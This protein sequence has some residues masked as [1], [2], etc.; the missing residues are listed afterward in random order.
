[1]I[2][3]TVEK[4]MSSIKN[5]YGVWMKEAA[6]KPYYPIQGSFTVLYARIMGLSYPQFLRYVRDVHGARLSGKGH[7]YITIYFPTQESAKNFAEIL[8]K[9]YKYIAKELK[10]KE[11]L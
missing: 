9:R 1:M 5:E 11:L 6:Q 3:F 4:M 10:N 2:Y 8:D 7:R